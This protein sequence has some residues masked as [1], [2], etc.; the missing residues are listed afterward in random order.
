MPT[1]I[2][3][4]PNNTGSSAGSKLGTDSKK[5]SHIYARTGSIDFISSSN[6]N[7]LGDFE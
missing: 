2:N 5:W 3:L 6:L 4:V 1:A 7:I